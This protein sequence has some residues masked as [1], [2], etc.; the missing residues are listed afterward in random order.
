MSTLAIQCHKVNKFYGK[1]QV[2]ENI[3]IEVPE[4]NFYG[5]VGMNGSGTSTMIKAIL[6]LVS[7]E[8]GLISVFGKSHRK[9][10][11]RE[12]ITYLPDRFSPP[13]HLKCK[14]FIPCLLDI[15]I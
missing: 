5:L 9:V 12:Q 13:I 14:D 1:Q 6:D 10:S 2:L 8:G 3:D 15:R 7:I 4:G 11:A